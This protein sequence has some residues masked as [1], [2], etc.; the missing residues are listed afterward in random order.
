MSRVAVPGATIAAY[1]WDYAE[2][3]EL[4][5]SFW[6]SAVE[7]DPET[8][9]L[10]EGIRFPLCHPHALFDLFAGSALQ[11]VKVESIASSPRSQLMAVAGDIKSGDW[12]LTEPMGIQTGQK[13]R[14]D[15]S[16]KAKVSGPQMGASPVMKM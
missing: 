10:D 2:K 13:V 8:A 1:D 12:V 9:K 11:Q 4:I 15:R 14:Q 6:D 5:R 3:M 7:L 16:Q